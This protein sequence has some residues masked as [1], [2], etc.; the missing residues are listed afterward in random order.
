MRNNIVEMHY[1]LIY[2]KKSRQK[3]NPTQYSQKAKMK[4][5]KQGINDKQYD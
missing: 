1:V 2:S 5:Y 4:W 3:K